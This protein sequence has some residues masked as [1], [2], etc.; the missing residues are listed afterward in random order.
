MIKARVKQ[1]VDDCFKQGMEK[2][3]WSD[4]A[5]GSYTVEA[6]KHTGQG[7]LATNLAMVVAGK[8]KKNPREIAGH[9]VELLAQDEGLLDKVEIAGPGFVNFFINDAVWQSVLPE[10]FKQGDSFG[11]SDVGAG[12]KVLV[13]FVSANPTGPL[14]VGHGRQAVLGDAIARLLA[15]TGHQVTREYYY[16][17]AGRQMRVLGES[18]KARYLEQLDLPF[19]FPEDGY[20][21]DYISEIAQSLID[22][23]G[24]SLKD[25]AD[26]LPFK[27]KAEGVIFEDI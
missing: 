26:Y 11:T 14:S 17:D 10:V 27:E 2:G 24:D 25:E 21:G 1:L 7:D 23:K 15:A 9:L 3:L 16:N 18:T 8:D 20:Q 4:A 13:E 12:K 6:P 5:A 22:E 19:E